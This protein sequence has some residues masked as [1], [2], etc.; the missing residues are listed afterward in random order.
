MKSRNTERDDVDELVISEAVKALAEM[1]KNVQES[2]GWNIQ[3]IGSESG[4]NL[5]STCC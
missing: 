1:D 3:G 2:F 4:F 5:K